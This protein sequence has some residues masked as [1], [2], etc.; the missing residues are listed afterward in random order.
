MA[1]RC[2]I[3]RNDKRKRMAA[4]QAERRAELKAKVVDA[5]LSWDERMT[6]RDALN[7][8]PRNGSAIRVRNR[9][10]ITGRPRGNYRK[11]N[12]CR[13]MFR[14]MASKGDLPG[15]IKSSW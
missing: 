3:F 14:D 4:N 1:K 5:S 10:M 15:V 9:C 7:A 2:S 12:I 13:N 11:F 8:L 6:A